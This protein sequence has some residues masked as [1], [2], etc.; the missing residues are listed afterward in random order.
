MS[1]GL[2]P[3]RIEVKMTTWTETPRRW[4]GRQMSLSHPTWQQP[5]PP[6][7]KKKTRKWTRKIWKRTKVSKFSR[8]PT[9]YEV[10]ETTMIPSRF[11][12]WKILVSSMTVSS[13]PTAPF[14]TSEGFQL[15][16]YTPERAEEKAAEMVHPR[17]RSMTKATKK[18]T[19]R[20]TRM[21]PFKRNSM[22]VE[23]SWKM[24]P[25]WRTTKNWISSINAACE[26]CKLPSFA[27]PL[28]ELFALLFLASMVLATAVVVV[29]LRRQSMDG[30]WWPPKHLCRIQK[31]PLLPNS[32]VVWRFPVMANRF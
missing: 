23:S 17:R 14:L 11:W 21:K 18:T 10:S 13:I 20:L 9:P 30:P 6:L 19:L 3:V 4:T 26:C 8:G 1:N 24:P 5:P 2:I 15:R 16:L 22:M 28:W 25:L 12:T 7:S 31:M 32:E 27:C 29:A